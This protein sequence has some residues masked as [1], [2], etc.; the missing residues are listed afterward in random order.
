MTQPDNPLWLPSTLQPAESR[1]LVEQSRLT[2]YWW[3]WCVIHREDRPMLVYDMGCGAG[4][5]CKIMSNKHPTCEIHGVDSIIQAVEYARANYAVAGRLQ[6]HRINIEL[7]WLRLLCRN[8]PDLITCF[9]TL[10]HLAS[11]DMFLEDVVAAL[12]PDGWF[13]VSVSAVEE[14]HFD[15]VT[16]QTRLTVADAKRMLQRYFT[17]VFTIDD[18]DFPSKDYYKGIRQLPLSGLG[19][20][21]IA[22]LS[23][24]KATN[25]RTT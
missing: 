4:Y 5:G 8:D 3:A 10:E 18:D 1:D 17:H 22:C 9:E 23:P 20:N 21:V 2:S 12:A 24:I 19:D 7:P 6:F 25:K 15:A 14:T 13:L 16:L 11:R